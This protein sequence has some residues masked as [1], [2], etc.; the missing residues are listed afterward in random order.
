MKLSAEVITIVNSPVAE[1]ASLSAMLP[2]SHRLL[3]N[4]NWS[5]VKCLDVFHIDQFVALARTLKR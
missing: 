1:V 3:L 5:R 2:L 4:D